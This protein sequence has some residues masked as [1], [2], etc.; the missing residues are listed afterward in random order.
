MNKTIREI[1]LDASRYW[2]ED[3]LS[4]ITIGML[5]LIIG[6]VLQAETLIPPGSFLSGLSGLTSFILVFGGIWLVRRVIP[7]LKGR[8]T[9]PRTG[10]VGYRRA[11]PVQRI[12]TPVIVVLIT[13]IMVWL[14]I[15]YPNASLAWVPLIQGVALAIFLLV[16]RL[17]S[18][19]V[20]FHLLAIFTLLLSL[21]ITLVSNGETLMIGAIFASFGLGLTLSGLIVLRRYLKHTQPKQET[22]HGE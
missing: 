17:R 21:G 14:F 10:Y 1:K 3:G 15:K 12:L 11:Y 19:L 20:R 13:A 2:F 18:G 16:I 5:F 8:L 9:Y 4:E 6:L 7:S 22:I